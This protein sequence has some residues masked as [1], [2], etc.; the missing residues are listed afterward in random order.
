MKSIL[1]AAA[2]S[3]ACLAMASCG[4][5]T[6]TPPEP[7]TL[8]L[9]ASIEQPAQI[10]ASATL[11]GRTDDNTRTVIEQE[12]IPH[13]ILWQANDD[14][15]VRFDTDPIS[16]SR[17]F[18]LESG[19]GTGNA[20]FAYS[21]FGVSYDQ[22]V[23]VPE[24]LPSSYA[25][26]ISGYPGMFTTI[27]SDNSEIILEAPREI[28]QGLENIAD[29]P[30]HGIAG[31]DG[32]IVF[33]CPFGIIH[34]PVTGNV[35]ITSIT[36]DTSE[37]AKEVSGRFLI[38]QDSHTTAFH[39]ASVGSQFSI[40]WAGKSALQLTSDPVSFYAVLPAGTYAVGTTFQF[41]QTNGTV[42]EKK[43]LEEF[44]VNR[45]QILNLPTVYVAQ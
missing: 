27:R 19:A 4:R 32:N 36:I 14:I 22:S 23:E 29:F 25:S 41:K 45:A 37:Q 42:I 38:D 1:T 40:S 6:T 44:T 31:A 3:L 9:H 11:F 2:F 28:F 16:V 15:V 43:T 33:H 13:P 34:F 12:T 10:A 17:Y 8:T 18:H 30:M 5:P 24:E 26:I 39:E 35:A 7:E 21:G 20:V